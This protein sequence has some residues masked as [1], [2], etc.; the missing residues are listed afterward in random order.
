VIRRFQVFAVALIVALSVGSNA[1][2]TATPAPEM[3][4]DILWAIEYTSRVAE[5]CG[6]SATCT[7]WCDTGAIECYCL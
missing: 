1:N 5:R 2:A 6:G 4:V 3:C 7:F